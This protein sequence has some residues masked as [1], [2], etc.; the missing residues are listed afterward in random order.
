MRVR[1]PNWISA[2]EGWNE[3]LVFFGFKKDYGLCYSRDYKYP[4][5]TAHN[6]EFGTEA[7]AVAATTW[8]AADESFKADMALY[9][10]AWNLT[11]KPGHEPTRDISA[12]NLFVK[13]CFAAAD[14]SSFDLSTLTVENFGGEAG[15]L[16]GT[17]A[18]NV[19]NLITAAGLPSCGLDLATLNN[20]IVAA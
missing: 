10:D 12:L 11:Q 4:T 16:L 1:L 15:D 2:F 9:A 14:A 20:P 7:S 19:G 6:T 3:G 17:S 13:G 5:I 18:P 8:N